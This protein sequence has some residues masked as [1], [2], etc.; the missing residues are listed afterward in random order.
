MVEIKK[1]FLRA[2]NH[3]IFKKQTVIQA[4]TLI[5]IFLFLNKFIRFLIEIFI[6]KYFGATAQ[7]DAFLIAL[8]IPTIVMSLAAGGIG[9][10]IIP[11]CIEGFKKNRE[12][13]KIFINQIFF[14][15]FLV[16]IITALIIYL[17]T[18]FF[19]KL[20]AYG[21]EKERFN[22]AVSLTKK[23]IPLG[24]TT[25]FVG[26]FTGIYQSR[27]QFLYPIVVS[28]VGS[29]LIIFCL[30]LFVNKLGVNSWVIGQLSFGIFS[31]FAL[32][33]LLYKRWEFFQKFCLRKI[34][35]KKIKKFLF[36]LIPL[37][38]MGGIQILNQ[39][40]DKTIA[41]H[42]SI[43]SVSILSFAQKTYTIPLTILVIPLITAIFPT[44]SSLALDKEKR[45]NYAQILKKSLFLTWSIIIPVSVILIILAEPIVRFLFQRGSFTSANTLLT[46]S[47]VR[48]YSL[49]LFAVSA[50][51]FLIK[52]FYSFKNT[53]TPLT[54]SIITVAINILGSIVL[55]K[56]LGAQGIALATSVALIIGFILYYRVIKN[57]YFKKENLKINIEEMSKII[58]ISILLG[59]ISFFLRPYLIVYQSNSLY[60]ILRLITVGLILIS[61][62]FVLS[63]LFK[64]QEIKIA[65]NYFKKE[66][67]RIYKK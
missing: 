29:A 51:Y 48:M 16:A 58:L 39:I 17:F 2:K 64:L 47:T 7:T 60:F 59:I 10:L 63:Q 21:F 61:I 46:A 5:T 53:K 13:E 34:Q 3:S 52:I 24:V 40:V 44:F 56:I 18:P 8:I 31:F 20:I 1:I 41:S 14:L 4:T 19:V 49:G 23:L 67:N 9:T 6:A 43:G 55:S 32:F 50:N 54:L 26:F 35:F 38:L 28:T 37:M 42:L 11:I 57:K 12:K 45:G 25:I 62:Y 36:I 15:W 22:L 30:L 27:N 33:F 66:L 65:Q